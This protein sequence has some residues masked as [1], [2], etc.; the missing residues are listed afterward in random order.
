LIDKLPDTIPEAT[1][2][3]KLAIFAGNPATYDDPSL[4]GNDLWETSLNSTLKSVFGWETEE[5]L[6][7]LIRRGRNGLDGLAGFVKHFVIKRGVN[8]E[9]FEGKMSHL[10]T[11]L[12]EMSVTIHF[13]CCFCLPMNSVTKSKDT[14][15][16]MAVVEPSP[17]IPKSS[18]KAPSTVNIIDVDSFEI[19]SE[20]ILKIRN[21][22]NK[23]CKGYILV[24]PDGKSPHTCYP[25]AL[26]DVLILPWDYTTHNSVMTLF[27]RS[28]TGRREELF[29]LCHA[30]RNLAKIESLQ[31]IVNR[32]QHGAHENAGFAYHGFG[33]LHDLLYIKN[34]QIDFH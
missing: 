5:D 20:N 27:A 25:F 30:C 14:T 29:E 23:S 7:S 33:G 28:Y 16:P 21:L 8:E 12:E 32:I 9:L 4:D 22:S 13:I 15:V 17:F 2:Y 11:K 1:E 26:H 3:D 34:K 18:D 10:M 6:E 19:G 24:F 31:G